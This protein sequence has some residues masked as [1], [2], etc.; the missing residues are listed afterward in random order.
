MPTT[1][2][3]DFLA[4]LAR[5]SEALRSDGRISYRGLKR[6]FRLT[7]DDLQ[8]VK[9]ELIHARRVAVEED[10]T[11]LVW[12]EAGSPGASVSGR[13]PALQPY[14]PRHVAA[15]TSTRGLASEGEKKQVTVLFCDVANSMVLAEQ[16]GAEGWHEVMKAFFVALTEAIHGLKGTVNQF[17]G[18]GLLAI[19]GAPIAHE[20]HALH[21]CMAAMRIQKAIGQL[22]DRVRIEHGLAMALRIGLNSGEVVMGTIGDALRTDY[23]AQGQVV[24]IAARLENLAEPGTVLLSES[25]HQQILNVCE[26]RP[27]GKHLLKGMSTPIEVFELLSVRPDASRFAAARRRGLTRFVGRNT[28]LEF[29]E[30]MRQSALSGGGVIIGIVGEP[31]MGKSRLLYEF[32]ESCRARGITVLTGQALSHGSSIPYL[33]MLQIFRAYYGITES[34]DPAMSRQ[35]VNA[36]HARMGPKFVEVAPLVHELLGVAPADSPVSNVDPDAKQR[37]LFE[38][39]KKIVQGADFAGGSILTCIEDLHWLDSGS[40][41]F[42]KEWVDALPGAQRIL[43]V[44]FRPGYRAEWMNR[45]WYLELHLNPLSEEAMR[46][47]LSALIGDD[48]STV[49]LS[50]SIFERTGGNPFFCE[51]IVQSLRQSGDLSHAPGMYRLHRPLRE[52]QI[53]PSVRSV[54][55]A[56]VDRVNEHEKSL[57]QIAAVIGRDFSSALLAHVSELPREQVDAA[58][59]SLKDGEFIFPAPPGSSNDWVFK[60]A[61]TQ[62]VALQLQLRD[63]RRRIHA[64]VAQGIETLHPERLS[65]LGSLLGY[66][67]EHAGEPLLAAQAYTRAA[68]QLRGNDRALQIDHIRRVLQLTEDLPASADRLQVRLQVLVEMIAGGAWRFTMSDED[69]DRMCDEA[70]ALAE[71][72]GLRELALM[73]RSGRAAAMGMMAGQIHDWHA[74]ISR[75]ASEVEGASA[76]VVATVRGQ[77]SYALYASGQL[78]RGLAVALESQALTGDD[79]RFGLAMGYSVLGAMQNCVALLLV[80]QGR[81]A[82]AFLNYR[83]AVEVLTAAGIT[84]ELIWNMANQAESVYPIGLEPD[85]PWVQEMAQNAF[86]AYEKA[87]RV[88]SD[89]TRGVAKRGR[90]AAL[91]SLRRFEDAEAAALE[92]LGHLRSRGA[93]LETEARCLAYLAEARL[94]C[95]KPD[96][97]LLAAQQSVQRSQ[98][99]GAR[100]FECC[101]HIALARVLIAR[102]ECGAAVDTVLDRALLLSR[103][104]G[105]PALVP[106]IVELRA[107]VQR[108]RGQEDAAK[109]GL[110]DALARYRTVKADGH[111]AR[112]EQELA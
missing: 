81:M 82:E 78:E 19:F 63:R 65:E 12:H 91:I 15:I 84:E 89:F 22:A 21:A 11:V 52:V 55:A 109:R 96:E 45:S 23:T 10:G 94:G 2:D 47:M 69:L 16:L 18:D 36:R 108:V 39:L 8:D 14:T 42:L 101:A 28:E 90:T 93:H 100:Y 29:L 5:I 97:A 73:I 72:A 6:R 43:V 106:Q 68:I 74:A 33:P 26:V 111:A 66:H 88:A 1:D 107:R 102:R 25:C 80:A 58:L 112:L 17:T 50:D 38:L 62:E 67:W 98:E 49:G 105:A 92:C 86:N 77:Y 7:N 35:K 46:E 4:L 76:E 71:A 104:V 79:P 99:Q 54:L 103:Q 9:D 44:S 70:R 53:P 56:R 57:L 48:P 51:E 13:E 64:K 59:R 40:E 95:G 85:H 60:H 87:E 61:L 83:H 31:G 32:Q 34:D 37:R 24:G 27:R 75:L 30:Q 110:Y 3:R 41:R 20:D